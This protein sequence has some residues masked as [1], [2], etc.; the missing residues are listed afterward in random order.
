M[1]IIPIKKRWYDAIRRREKLEEY[2]EPTGYW[3]ARFSGAFGCSVQEAE[4]QRTEAW[5]KLRNGYGD[6]K[7]TIT[8]RARLRHGQGRPEWGAIPGKEYIILD[9]LE[10]QE[11]TDDPTPDVLMFIG[12]FSTDGHRE[13]VQVVE[14]FTQG[15]CFWFARILEERFRDQY[16]A[17]IV[18][19][20]VAN[21]FATRIGGDR[22]Y[23][24]TGD[25]TEGHTWEPWAACSDHLLRQRITDDCIMF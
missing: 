15:C 10:V 6:D 9:V 16:G 14:A 21:H 5:I 3:I 19:D 7:P 8:I 23:D 22:V 4:A 12:R 1:L 24:I 20:Y 25:V 17:H 18:V 13:R 11:P 2:R